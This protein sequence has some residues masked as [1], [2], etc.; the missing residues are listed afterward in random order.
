[1]YSFYVKIGIDC[2]KFM[3]DLETVVMNWLEV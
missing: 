3:A 2:E 1:M